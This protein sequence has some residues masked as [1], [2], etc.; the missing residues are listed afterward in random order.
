MRNE[1]STKTVLS[2]NVKRHITCIVEYPLRQGEETQVICPG[3]SLGERTAMTGVSCHLQ[4]AV[5]RVRASASTPNTFQPLQS[6]DLQ[7]ERYQTLSCDTKFPQIRINRVTR[8]KE[9]IERVIAGGRV[10]KSAFP[11]ASPQYPALRSSA[12]KS[13]VVLWTHFHCR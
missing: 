8:F 13:G 4:S 6:C 9:I 2:A 11:V 7:C 5:R 3:D 1:L 10:L 12:G